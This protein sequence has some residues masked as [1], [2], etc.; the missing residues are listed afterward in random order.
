VPSAA[1]VVGAAVASGP[2]VKAAGAPGAAA[3]AV[4][5]ARPTGLAD[6]AVASGPAAESGVSPAGD[7]ADA[8]PF[9]REAERADGD[10]GLAGAPV[11]AEEG[12]ESVGAPHAPTAPGARADAE[13]GGRHRAPEPPAPR[14][15]PDETPAARW[16]LIRHAN[17]ERRARVRLEHPVLGSLRLDFAL[18][19]G[20]LDVRVLAPSVLSAIRLERD[21]DQIR[22]LLRDAGAQLAA[23]RVDV[24][25]DAARAPTHPRRTPAPRPGG[26]LSLEA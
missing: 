8:E 21:V 10:P 4:E 12:A 18:E 19:E 13:T 24:P 14:A 20:A 23:M 26:R 6:P 17:G 22:A 1:K 2:S 9:A 25:D 16:S 11:A 5:V 3:S 7:A 15:D